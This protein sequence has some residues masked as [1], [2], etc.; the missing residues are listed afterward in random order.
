MVKSRSQNNFSSSSSLSNAG[1]SVSSSKSGSVSGGSS[2]NNSSVSPSPNSIIQEERN[3]MSPRSIK[4]LSISKDKES[5]EGAF[6]I[7]VRGKGIKKIK[8]VPITDIYDKNLELPYSPKTVKPA[9]SNTDNL[10]KRSK[11]KA[12]RTKS[13][14]STIVEAESKLD[15]S[16]SRGEKTSVKKQDV[17]PIKPINVTPPSTESQPFAARDSYSAKVLGHEKQKAKV[18]PVGKILPEVKRVSQSSLGPIGQKINPNMSTFNT[19]PISLFPQGI[20]QNSPIQQFFPN[21]NPSLQYHSWDHKVVSPPT[22]MPPTAT[23]PPPGL[24]TPNSNWIYNPTQYHNVASASTNAAR[25]GRLTKKLYKLDILLYR[26]VLL[27]STLRS[28]LVTTRGLHRRCG[29]RTRPS[30]RGWD[31]TPQPRGHH[32]T[33]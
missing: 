3:S 31:S 27:C 32:P 14:I 24:P 5:D 11:R 21:S 28:G 6:E 25:D 30:R 19:P 1:S 18:T 4:S 10:L 26:P 12:T 20:P 15:K 13:D 33:T 2:S 9:S 17:T 22:I 23:R 16:S 29:R 7:A 8:G